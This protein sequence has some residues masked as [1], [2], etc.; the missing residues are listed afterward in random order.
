MN[1]EPATEVLATLKAR[2]ILEG[3]KQPANPSEVARALEMPA[4]SVHYWTRR[5]KEVDLLEE[6]S[7]E[8]RTRTYK[9]RLG[10]NPC[11]P[12][13]CVP[14]ISNIMQ[15][16]DKV[17]MDAA[18]KHDLAGPATPTQL[19]EIGVHELRLRPEEAR[20]LVEALKSA[21]PEVNHQVPD[22]GDPY[23]VSFIVTPGKV[24]DYF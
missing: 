4:N 22:A 24:S 12:E 13:A 11:E 5:L 15:A 16:L 2:L 17:V 21:M 20:F 3:Y 1:N 10:E 7:Q 9:S 6:I 18:E 19:P 8:G 14:F 23:T